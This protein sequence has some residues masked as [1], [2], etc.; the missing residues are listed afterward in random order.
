MGG[1]PANNLMDFQLDKS[2]GNGANTMFVRE[3]LE[4]ENDNNKVNQDYT[5]EN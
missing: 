2:F 5:L 3:R 1:Y 4:G